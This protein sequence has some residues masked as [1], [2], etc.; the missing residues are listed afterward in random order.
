MNRKKQEELISIV[1]PV[2]NAAK[3]LPV[4]YDCLRAQS[5]T[6]WEWVVVNDGS[7][8]DSGR[9]LKE[10]AEHDNRI[11]YYE[12]E[13]SGCCKQPRDVAVLRSTSQYVTCLDADDY[14]D[15][16]YLQK[17]CERMDETQVDI[18]YPVM[19]FL[20]VNGKC[21]FDLPVEGFD[22]T[23]VYYGRDLVGETMPEWRIGCNGGLYKKKVWNDLSYIEKGIH[24]WINYADEVDERFYMAR[25]NKV[26]FADTVYYYVCNEKSIT[27]SFSPKLFHKLKTDRMLL[28]FIKK[29]FGE[30]GKEYS[31]MNRQVFYTLRSYMALYVRNFQHLYSC[32]DIIF[33]DLKENF[34]L[35]DKS[36]LTVLERIKFLNFF[37]FK[38]IF[39]LFCLKYSPSCLL[40]KTILRLFPKFYAW[41]IY[42]RRAEREM[43]YQITETYKENVTEGKPC[44]YVVSMFCGNTSHGGLVDRLRGAVSAYAVCKEVG[45]NFKIHFVHPFLLTDYIGPNK[46]D[47]T[48]TAGELSFCKDSVDRVIL[49]SATST[50][51]ERKYQKRFLSRILVGAGKQTHVYTN[52]SFCYDEGFGQL[53]NEL[54]RPSAALQAHLNEIK[55]QIGSR[56][57]SVSARFLNLMGDFN[58]ENYSEPLPIDE[59]KVLMDKCIG[60]LEKLHDRFNSFRMLVC[61]DS[62][63]FLKKADEFD[64]TFVIP[65]MVSHIDNDKP[66]SY[67]YYEKT[68]LDFF[69]I[70]SAEHVFLLKEQRMMNSGFPY[71]AALS[72]GKAFETIEF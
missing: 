53:F 56:Y 29:E 38:L 60:M 45:R 49:D 46:Y 59:Q 48:V 11:K 8:D 68:F 16:D 26:A 3:F 23:K 32:R 54:F 40:E 36:C 15:V 13:N 6:N 65:G 17:M 62:V 22:R 20:D 12:Q 4:L 18:V 25:A 51:W 34:L 37:S 70:A 10:W 66:R 7:T 47:W 42:R 28:E 31:L 30:T 41:A 5:Y 58:E 43:A 33:R 1:T 14:I 57:I 71:A 63:G 55:S 61:S 69:T 21:R 9:M 52:A 24:A 39:I 72:G 19:R 50:T 2:Y 27:N 64:Y 35:I 67:E 44:D